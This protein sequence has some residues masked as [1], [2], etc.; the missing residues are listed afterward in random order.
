MTPIL[1][2]ESSECALASL[3]MVSNAHGLHLDLS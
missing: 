2:S 3:A 1:Q